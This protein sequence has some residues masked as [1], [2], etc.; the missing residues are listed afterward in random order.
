MSATLEKYELKYPAPAII[1]SEDQN[2]QYTA[3]LIE[4]KKRGRLS[5]EDREYARLLAALIEKYEGEKFPIPDATPQE[6]LVELIE[7]NGLRQ[8][9]LVPILGPESVVS[10]IVN[11]KRP[12]S[13]TNIEKLSRRFHV[14]PAVFF[15]RIPI[16]AIHQTTGHKRRAV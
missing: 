6:I 15:P 14:S 7:Q 11:G 3:K 12:L 10:E 16:R 1:E 5:A 2:D 9:D 8:R 13:K 4:L